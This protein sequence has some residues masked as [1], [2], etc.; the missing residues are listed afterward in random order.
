MRF[1]RSSGILLHPTSLPGR[2]GIGDLGA[3]ARRFA[4]FLHSAGQ[5]IW[6]VLPLN[7]TGF[8]DSPYQSFSAFA[9][10]PLLISLEELRDRGYLSACDLEGTPDFPE[11][12]V[13]FS[14]VIPFRTGLLRK[15]AVYFF[16]HAEAEDRAQFERFCRENSAWLDDFA[17]FMAA[18]EAH[19][20]RAWTEWEPGLA[21]RDPRPL[22]AWRDRLGREIEVHRYW[23][24]EFD[25]Q[26]RALK[27][28]CGE[29]GIRMMGDL[30]IYVAHD[31]ADVWSHPELFH[32]DPSG[33]PTKQAGVPPDYFSA[34]GQLWG[35][36]IYRWERMR[37]SGFPWWT[38]RFRAALATF[39]VLRLDHF[40]GFEAYWE[41]DAGETTAMKGRWVK[42]PG[43]ELFRHLAHQ[44]G[45]LP[46]VAENLGVITPEVEAIRHE[47]CYPGMALLQF[48]FGNDPQAPSF[49]P[50]NYPRNLVAYTGGHD[51]DTVEG[52]WRGGV[53]EST[54]SEEDVRREHAFAREYL[55]ACDE[56]MHVVMVREV[57]RSVAD[58]AI[59]PLQDVFGLGSEARMNTPATLG[60]NWCWRY[61]RDELTDEIA[62]RLR[63]WAEIY[64][65]L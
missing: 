30:P 55:G 22:D 25:R 45:E 31:S 32:L 58:T 21:H 37:E 28:Y 61:S 38:E 54:R 2:Y 42:G 20:L 15:A 43:A 35:N 44:L 49:Q 34:T 9:G 65:R 17:M 24:F 41:V 23:Q 47:F 46:I 10:N 36:P 16:A 60:G 3:E 1:P 48:A 27:T 56:P 29:R 14:R 4:D 7:P 33:R 59:V 57:M 53:G 39:D 64:G 26:W 5:R 13:E 18:K 40:R 50:H 6:Q 8:G 19:G 11:R 52:W 12:A 62:T 63:R 51:N